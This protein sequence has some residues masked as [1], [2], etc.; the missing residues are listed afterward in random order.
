MVPARPGECV[1]SYDFTPYYFGSAM[2]PEIMAEAMPAARIV[3]ML[4]DPVERALSDLNMQAGREMMYT[5]KWGHPDLTN[6]GILRLMES[7]NALRDDCEERFPGIMRAAPVEG[8][9][10]VLATGRLGTGSEG[11]HSCVEDVPRQTRFVTDSLYRKPMMRW[12]A[13]FQD[14]Q[15]LVVRQ[16]ELRADSAAVVARIVA[17]FGL[18][19]HEFPAEAFESVYRPGFDEVPPAYRKWQFPFSDEVRAEV[20]AF[21]AE[22][23]EWLEREFSVPSPSP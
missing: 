14:E 3:V 4:R 17:H 9:L 11:W 21:L 20:A 10:R 1:A 7:A 22:E 2:A 12:R 15:I 6:D 5:G 13:A 23:S 16:E 8:M 19:A 18:P